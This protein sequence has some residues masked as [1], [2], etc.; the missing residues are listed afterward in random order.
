MTV[1]RGKIVPQSR[2][3]N[4][5]IYLPESQGFSWSSERLSR[6]DE[7]SDSFSVPFQ[8]DTERHPVGNG[9]RFR[10][11]FPPDRP[12]VASTLRGVAVDRNE[13]LSVSPM[14]G[15]RPASLFS[16]SH[17]PTTRGPRVRFRVEGLSFG[18]FVADSAGSAR[19]A[20]TSP[21]ADRGLLPTPKRRAGKRDM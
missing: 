1:P 20:D 19:R 5:F 9:A 8:W 6:L 12:K 15:G 4:L 16:V 21:R 2:P 18:R 10:Y 14:A 3:E 17:S 11:G 13:A 7:W